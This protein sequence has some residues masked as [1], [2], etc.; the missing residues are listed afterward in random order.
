MRAGGEEAKNQD[1][2]QAREAGGAAR[3]AAGRGGAE[4]RECRGRAAGEAGGGVGLDVRKA[5]MR[6]IVLG[7]LLMT[8]ATPVT[9]ADNI[10][11]GC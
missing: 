5:M 6:K 7:L 3:G 4:A 11:G 2:A 10:G 1:G 8:S 9:I